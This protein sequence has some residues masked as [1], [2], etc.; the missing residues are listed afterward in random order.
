MHSHLALAL[1]AHTFTEM[2]MFLA[3]QNHVQDMCA[4]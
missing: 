1:H 4:V 2:G 3:V